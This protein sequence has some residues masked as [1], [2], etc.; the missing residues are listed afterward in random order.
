[1]IRKET[2]YAY[3]DLTIVPERITHIASRSEVDCH[4]KDGYLPIFTAPMSCVVN[5]SNYTSF[6]QCH[7]H[8]ILPTTV[9]YDIRKEQLVKGY[10]V[11]MSMI[12]AKECFIDNMR[13]DIR[14]C[15][16]VMKL[17]I[18][19]ANGHMTK[20]FYLCHDIKTVCKEAG[21]AIEIMSGNIANPDTIREYITHDIDY[22]RVGIGGGSGCTT[23]S[24]TGCH[25]PMASL[26]EE[27]KYVQHGYA[28]KVKIVADGGIRNYDDVNKALA[29]GADYVMIGGLFSEMVE[30]ASKEYEM[31]QYG[32]Y[33][34]FEFN[35]D[36][37]NMT[38]TMEEAKRSIINGNPMYHEVYGMST[39]RAQQERGMSVL[40]TSEGTSH[41]K[42][43]KYTLRQWT[44]NMES[45]L[46]SIMSY[47]DARNL[48]EFIGE[49]I[50]VVNSSASINSV[51]K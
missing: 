51:N 32:R 21:L 42:R 18:D 37:A 50:L 29:L 20:L 45:Y 4:D 28:K 17:C 38:D 6:E 24:N 7:I 47:C 25:Y 11:A 43:I 48:K 10:W 12:E 23:T 36:K 35:I 41:Y 27:C 26:I 22:V 30:A 8:S 1:M 49:P 31:D 33:L 5:E 40:K 19:V 3:K 14:N 13:D 2:K 16:N 34:P 39:K 9:D 46:K 44:D 15:T